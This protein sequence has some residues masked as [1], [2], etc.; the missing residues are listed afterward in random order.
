MTLRFLLAGAMVLLF[1]AIRVPLEARLDAEHEKAFFRT[2]KLDLSLREKIGQSA[3]VAALSGF[4]AVIADV[5][6]I[7]AH[8]AWEKTEYGK[9]ALIFENVT[10]LQPRNYYFWDNAAWHMAW[11]GSVF[12]FENTKQPRLAIRKK[13]QKEFFDLG[14][15]FL[16]RGIKNNPDNYQL[17]Q[18]YALFLQ[19]KRN[20]P[21]GASEQYRLGSLLKDAPPYMHRAAVIQLAYCPGKQREAYAQ[22]RE[23]WFRGQDERKP[24]VITLIRRLENE[25]Q[26]PSEKRIFKIGS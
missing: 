11:N 22:L 23:L 15:S 17:R 2:A 6:W 25:L 8:T 18:T 21:C 24:T 16:V 7:D 1:G 4:R 12:A 10:T 19:Q 14:E 9:M 3:F 13:E 5:L 26:I 20:D